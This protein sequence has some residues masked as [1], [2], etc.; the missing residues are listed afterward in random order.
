MS[1][2][3]GSTWTRR[4]D[5]AELAGGGLGLGQVLGHVVLVE[6]HL[7]LQVAGLDEVAVDEAQM[8]D[9]G[10]DQGVGQHGAQ[11]AAAAQGHVAVEQ[12]ALALLADAVKRICRL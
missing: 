5:G 3:T 9:A 6:Q 1:V 11:G 12:L 2:T 7:P 10:A 4:V 8:A